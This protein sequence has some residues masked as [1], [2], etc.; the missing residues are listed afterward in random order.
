MSRVKFHKRSKEK[1]SLL[2]TIQRE[3]PKFVGDKS[4]N[5]SIEFH[6]FKQS[7]LPKKT[8]HL[9]KSQFRRRADEVKVSLGNN[10]FLEV[11]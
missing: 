4:Q 8:V 3:S 10:P 7:F 5:G 2:V 6:C 11:E 1:Q 9:K